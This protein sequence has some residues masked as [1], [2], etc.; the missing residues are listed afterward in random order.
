VG[1]VIEVEAIADEFVDL[2]FGRAVEAAF[3][4]AISATVAAVTTGTAAGY[5]AALVGAAVSAWTIS[6]RTRASSAGAIFSG[7]AIFSVRLRCW[8]IGHCLL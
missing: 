7:R 8:L 1:L 5:S 2:D 4:S 6:A 3:A